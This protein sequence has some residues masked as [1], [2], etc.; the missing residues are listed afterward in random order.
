MEPLQA[1]LAFTAI[2]VVAI[3]LG[4]FFLGRFASKRAQRRLMARL[5]PC[6]EASEE[7]VTAVARTYGVRIAVGS[8]IYEVTGPVEAVHLRVRQVSGRLFSVGYVAIAPKAVSALGER[9][10]LL[11]QLL[12]GG[13]RAHDQLET[14]ALRAERLRGDDVIMDRF[15]SA[16]AALRH[17]EFCFAEGDDP[18]RAACYVLTFDG[19]RIT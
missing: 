16:E 14:D 12:P 1:A 13:E 15:F 4:R 19:R 6:R 5:E 3:S 8:P 9:G 17:M 10:I 7:D 11:E 2:L 18:K